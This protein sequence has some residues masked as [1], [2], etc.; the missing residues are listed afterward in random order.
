MHSLE[1]YLTAGDVTGDA[2]WHARGLALAQRIIDQHARA[3]GWRIPEHYDEQWTPQLEYHRE[4][5]TDRFRPYGT[6]PGHSFEWAR[7][8]LGLHDRLAG[9]GDSPGWLAEAAAALFQM[10]VADAWAVDGQPGLVYT[11]D[12]D[13]APIVAARQ[14]WVICEAILAADALDRTS[15]PASTSSPAGAAGA[16][17]PAGPGTYA[18]W[19]REWWQFVDRHVIDR[20]HGGWWHELGPDLHPTHTVWTGKPDLYHAYQALLFPSLPS[21]PCAA[22]VL[23]RPA[24]GTSSSGAPSG[25]PDQGP[26]RG[27]QQAR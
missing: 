20:V 23:A 11:V 18:S 19:L 17:S 5:P 6:T 14:H 3:N 2:V 16:S 8:L 22:L 9:A 13:G 26:E 21:S 4:L 7:L 24:V 25:D 10:A 12:T 15:S 27:H 1:A